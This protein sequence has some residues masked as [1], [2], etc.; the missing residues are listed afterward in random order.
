MQ[1]TTESESDIQQISYKL[2]ILGDIAV[3][4]S[5]IAQRF[6]NGKFGTLHEPTIGALFLTKKINIQ[7]YIAKFEIWDTAGQERYHALT[8]MYYRNANA[9][10]VVFDVTNPQSYERAQKWVAELLEKANSGIIIAL[11]G[12]K[13]DLDENRKVNPEE[14][15]RYADQIGSFYIEVSAKINLN[16]DKM[17]E[18]IANK[19]PKN[20]VKK[21]DV[22]DEK[23]V[24]PSPGGC[25]NC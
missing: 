10:V 11:C 21:G 13:V 16:I 8:P 18:D 19:L 9:A 7:N 3:G 17:F 5:S 1:Q 24:E 4:K 25:G 2:V 14:V 20:V 6:V 15:K 22:I 23:P 12:N